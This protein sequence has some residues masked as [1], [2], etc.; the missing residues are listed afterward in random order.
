VRGQLFS[1][2]FFNRP[3]ARRR[4]HQVGQQRRWPHAIEKKRHESAQQRAGGIGGLCHAHHEHDIYPGDDDQVHISPCSVV[5][6]RNLQANPT[7]LEGW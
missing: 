3:F 6:V 4:A 5:V 1:L 7:I 2:T